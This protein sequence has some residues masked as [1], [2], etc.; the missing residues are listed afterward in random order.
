MKSGS[1]QFHGGVVD[2]YRM[3]VRAF[4]LVPA[5]TLFLVGLL[6]SPSDAATS[7]GC[8]G[9]ITSLTAEG[10]P[11]DQLTVP[12][13]GGTDAHPFQ[14]MWGGNVMWQ[15]Q[16]AQQITDGTWRVNVQDPSWLFALGELVTGHPHGLTGSISGQEDNDTWSGTFSPNLIEPL[17]LPGKFDVGIVVNGNGGAQCIGTLAVRVVDSPGRTPTWWMALILTIAGLVMILVF[18]VSKWTNPIRVRIDE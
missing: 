18:G 13:T 6:A 16:T 5:A 14:I 1:L 3:R 11:L 15:A 12:G 17:P 2:N 7:A 4:F 10:A 9:T 8:S